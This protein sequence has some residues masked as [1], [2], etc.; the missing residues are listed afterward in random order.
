MNSLSHAAVC[1]WWRRW[2]SHPDRAP[3]HVDG[4]L[5]PPTL[6]VCNLGGLLCDRKE[7]FDGVEA[8]TGLLLF[9]CNGFTELTEASVCRCRD[10]GERQGVVAGPG[11]RRRAL[12]AAAGGALRQTGAHSHPQPV[13]SLLRVI[14]P[15]NAADFHLERDCPVSDLDFELGL[16]RLSQLNAKRPY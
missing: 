10:E 1:E 5:I 14:V 4:I 15:A 12:V 7:V 2:G 13:P 3:A 16:A 11:Q 9:L 8:A 6:P